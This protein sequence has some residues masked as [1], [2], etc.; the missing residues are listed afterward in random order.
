MAA[1]PA[2]DRARAGPSGLNF[3]PVLQALQHE[4]HELGL[5]GGM[6]HVVWSRRFHE[7]PDAVLQ[8]DVDES[9][10]HFV[11][12]FGRPDGFTSPGFYSDARVMRMIGRMGFAYDGDAIGG[13]PRRATADGDRSGTG[14]SR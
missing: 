9:Y 5:H 8:A 7:L 11:R 3:V 4:G 10:G 1:V 13:E 12:N 6:D 14:P 2:R